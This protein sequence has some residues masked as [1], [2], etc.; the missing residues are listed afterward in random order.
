MYN[1]AALVTSSAGIARNNVP[2]TV[3]KLTYNQVL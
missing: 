2:S 1:I 3:L